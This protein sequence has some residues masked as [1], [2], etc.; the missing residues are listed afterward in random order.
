MRQFLLAAAAALTFAA[1]DWA[2][3]ASSGDAAHGKQLF[4]AEACYTCHGT[5]AA[6]GGPSGPALAHQGLPA[7]A[8]MQQL[9]HPQTRMPAYSDKVLPDKDVADIVAYIQS[10]S[11]GPKPN[12]K[13]IPLLNQ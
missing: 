1:P 6:G 9:R 3:G 4:M 2:Q 8:I 5:T 7:E 12:A 11:Q 10:L 13:D